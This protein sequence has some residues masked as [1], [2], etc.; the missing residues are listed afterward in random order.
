MS[1][2]VTKAA[3]DRV[4]SALTTVEC[5]ATF[6]RSARDN[7][8]LSTLTKIIKTYPHDTLVKM[9]N[10]FAP[11]LLGKI[12]AYFLP[13]VLPHLTPTFKTCPT[14]P[15]QQDLNLAVTGEQQ[16]PSAEKILL[17]CHLMQ[18][19]R[20][21]STQARVDIIEKPSLEENTE[22]TREPD[23]SSVSVFYGSTDPSS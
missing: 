10:S 12:V 11:I 13:K 1:I 2:R 15:V 14:N 7:T 17:Y 20:Y 3:L 8:V 6:S 16:A 21:P 22:P 23:S 19:H 5:Q 9:I 18:L 4:S